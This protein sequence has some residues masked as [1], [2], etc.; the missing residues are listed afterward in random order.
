M[1]DHGKMGT[2]PNTKMP[3]IGT[4]HQKVLFEDNW[5]QVATAAREKV[6]SK[7]SEETIANS[8]KTMYE[9]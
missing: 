1:I 3:P 7:Y 8:Y 4:R 6:L 2:W 5:K 9:G